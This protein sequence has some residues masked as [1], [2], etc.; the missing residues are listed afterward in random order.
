MMTLPSLVLPDKSIKFHQTSKMY[1]SEKTEMKHGISMYF[2][3][4]D[5]GN[6]GEI[7]TQFNWK[8]S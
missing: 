2:L 5:V 6:L 7:R 1:T 4:S 8:S 3:I